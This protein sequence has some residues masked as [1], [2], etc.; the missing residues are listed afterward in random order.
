MNREVLFMVM[1]LLSCAIAVATD[2]NI[3]Q[4]VLVSRHNI[5]QVKVDKL[6]PLSIG[7]GH[8]CYTADITGMQTFPELYRDGIPLSTMSEWGWHSFPNVERYQLSDVFKYVNTYGEKVPYPIGSSAGYEYLRANP[9]QMGLALIGLCRGGGDSLL[10]CELSEMSQQ[11]NVWEGVL[12]SQFKVSGSAVEITT[13]CHPE[14]DELVYRLQSP[15]FAERRLGIRI[16][17]PFPSVAFGKEPAVWNKVEGHHTEIMQ[18][19]QNKWLIKHQINDFVYYCH[20]QTSVEARL[21]KGRCHDYFLYPLSNDHDFTLFVEFVQ[22]QN[23]ISDKEDYTMVVRKN[24]LAWETFWKSGGAVDLSGSKDPR[25]KELER[26]IILSQ[27]LTA[28]QSRQ[29]YPPQETGL[30]CN[31]WYGKFHLEMHWWHSV[32]FALWGR[33]VYLENTLGWYKNIQDVARAYTIQ[34]GYKGI[35]W[36]KMVG[37]NGIESPSSIGPLLIW[38]QPHFIYYAELLYR[39]KNQVR[40]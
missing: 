37:P 4:K 8:F 27:Y 1:S 35:R 23:S 34:Q 31:S 21:E 32:H 25:W 38:Q 36:P 15:L 39:E 6:S 18:N 2:G 16:A 28:I 24:R 13:L 9:H 10:F 26:R 14:R 29:Q 40:C 33:S 7:N 3:N 30:T 5:T 22:D 19:G 11:L 17:F 12:N 20:L